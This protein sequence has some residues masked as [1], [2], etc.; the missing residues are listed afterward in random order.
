MEH[1]ETFDQDTLPDVT[2]NADGSVTVQ[3]DQAIKRGDT[4]I[5]S[6]S[7]RKPKTGALRGIKL[8]DLLNMDYSALAVLLPRITEP[9]LTPA[10]IADMDPADFTKVASGAIGF[11][12]SQR[13]Q[14]RPA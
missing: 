8:I 14:S 2:R 6:L 11:F 12:V 7:L 4:G 5:L 9:A 3:L 10:D 1:T 13:A